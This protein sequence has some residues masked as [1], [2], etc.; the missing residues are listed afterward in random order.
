MAN[1]VD[2]EQVAAIIREVAAA[3]ILPRFRKLTAG[4]IVPK[5]SRGDFATTA[6]LEAERLLGQRM[7][8]LLPG[9]LVVGEEAAEKRPGLLA[10]IA[11][12]DPV[13]IIDPLDGTHNF[14]DGLARF[15][16]MVALARAGE[17]EAAWIHDPLAGRTVIA[18]RGGGAWEAGKRLAVARPGPLAAMRGA[19]Y[20]TAGRPGISPKLDE[21]RRLFASTS[22]S[23]CAGC[24]YL[25]LAR[26]ESHFALFTRLLPWDHAAGTLI[27]R[28][29]GGY[30]ACLDG[31]PYRP[32]RQAGVLLLAPDLASWE[33]IAAQVLVRA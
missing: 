22:Y 20:A 13:W 23:R 28:E 4:D 29:A 9:S 24:E 15:A 11:G 5:G 1:D 30:H 2:P 18:Q 14:A 32:T 25:A 17:T 33:A 7:A 10:A 3:A 31:T 27:H 26:R 19:L 16:V 21:A 8:A 12:E 6:D